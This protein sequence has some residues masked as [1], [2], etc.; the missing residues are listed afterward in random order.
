[1]TKKTRTDG[2]AA[3]PAEREMQALIGHRLRARYAEILAEPIPDKFL[4]L[5]ERLDGT[6]AEAHPS[7]PG[8]NGAAAPAPVAALFR[9][10][11]GR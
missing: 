6:P 10:E 8:A 3:M 7:S 11:N 1:M 4:D 2:P 9:G 5:L